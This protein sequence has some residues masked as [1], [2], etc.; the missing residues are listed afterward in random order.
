M[1]VAAA[2]LGT[3]LGVLAPGE[4]AALLL[5]ALVTIAAVTAA[6]GP[7]ERLAR[8]GA[9][10]PSGPDVPQGPAPTDPGPA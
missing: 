9:V 6:A 5:G 1:P 10:E 2:T 8:A 3:G 4:S 7:L